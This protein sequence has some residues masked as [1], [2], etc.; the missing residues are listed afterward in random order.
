MAERDDLAARRARHQLSEHKGSPLYPVCE[1]CERRWPCD[2]A[3]AF[4]TLD[5]FLTGLK[6]SSAALTEEIKARQAAEAAR[7][8]M[9]AALRAVT[10]RLALHHQGHVSPYQLGGV[11]YSCAT[12]DELIEA[13]QALA[14]GADATD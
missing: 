10:D 3:V 8:R 6:L 1:G 2:A 5:E 13:R 7:D 11:W 12:C 9:R 4:A 14:E